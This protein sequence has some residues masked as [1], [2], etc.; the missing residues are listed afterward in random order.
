M[1]MFPAA[2]S[3][4]PDNVTTVII[5]STSIEVTWDPPLPHHRN[6][7]ITAYNVTVV[8]QLSGTRVFSSVLLNTSALVTS[9][10]PYTTYNFVVLARTSVGYGPAQTVSDTTPE[11]SKYIM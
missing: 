11:D 10:R 7:L 2:P 3:G 1:D 5:N 9:L 4:T 6:G 8:E